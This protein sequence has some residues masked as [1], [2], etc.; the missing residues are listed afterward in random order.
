MG[1]REAPEMSVMQRQQEDLV[2]PRLLAR[3][4]T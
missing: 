1:F 2:C 3:S 4:R